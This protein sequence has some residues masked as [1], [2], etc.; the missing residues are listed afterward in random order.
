[1]HAASGLGAAGATGPVAA[2]F[3]AVAFVGSPVLLLFFVGAFFR[4]KQLDLRPEWWLCVA[5]V[6]LYFLVDAARGPGPRVA[7]AGPGGVEA[8]AGA[9]AV[10]VRGGGDIGGMPLEQFERLIKQDVDSKALSPPAAET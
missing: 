4:W 9:V 1:M 6:L 10:R 5:V 7:V 2:G 8:E 3:A